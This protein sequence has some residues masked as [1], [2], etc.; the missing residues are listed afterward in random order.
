M[1]NE[2]K[3]NE[4][5]S[6][7]NDGQDISANKDQNNIPPQVDSVQYNNS[8][9]ENMQ[10]NNAASNIPNGSYAMPNNSYAAPNNSY[11]MPNNG[12]PN[13]NYAMPNGNY[14]MPN[15]SYAMPNG[16][17]YQPVQPKP[18]RLSKG[19]IIGISV[20]I[21]AMLVVIVILSAMVVKKASQLAANTEQSSTTENKF[22]GLDTESADAAKK[23]D[24]GR[25]VINLPVSSKPQLESRY[26]ADEETG[27]LT[28]EGVAQ[29]VLPSQ[30]LVGVYND[31]PYAMSSLG[32][33][34]ILTSDGYILTNAHVIDGANK[35]KVTLNDG[36][37]Y[38]T[39]VIGIDKAADVAVI[40]I[41]AENL[42]AAE[43]GNSDE[44]NLGEAV[45]VVG[46]AGSFENSITYGYISALDREVET[47]YSSSGVLNCIQTDAALNPGN[48]GGALV[49]MYGQVIGLSVG[50]MSHEYYEGIG[51]AIRINDVIPIA[52]DLMANGFVPGRARIGVSYI[53]ITTELAALYDVPVG[54]CVMEIDSDCDIASKD[55][56]I[57]DIITEID[58]VYVYD[59]ATITKAMKDK[60]AGESVTLTVYRKTITE[61]VSEFEVEI[62]LAQKYD[63]N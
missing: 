35:M 13:N 57:Y 56:E 23:N 33:G 58:G 17:P 43:L 26:Y 48:S 61:E 38:E 5:N 16:M 34:I 36:T 50:G 9:P 8:I 37:Q 1:D 21:A 27:L 40:K 44:A 14:A 3:E 25:V 62:V 6:S 52:E 2:F 30:V 54:L 22:S 45:A 15:S 53:P 19:W 49:N 28:T 10:Q 39:K 60:Y 7:V 29:K 18:K 59:A 32:S 4:N 63:T 55:V 24:D 20:L 46:A 11:G 42:T 47:N 51:F 31:T 41:D 12:M